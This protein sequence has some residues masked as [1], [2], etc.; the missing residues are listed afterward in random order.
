MHLQI[1]SE[2]QNELLDFVALFKSSFYLGSY[3]SKLFRQ[4]LAYFD[5]INYDEEVFSFLAMK[6]LKKKLNLFSLMSLQRHFDYQICRVFFISKF[7]PPSHVEVPF[8]PPR[9][10]NQPPTSIYML[11]SPQYFSHL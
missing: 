2:E 8:P 6:F 9:R 1:L 4:Q 5:D 11:L 7:L 10:I 3:N